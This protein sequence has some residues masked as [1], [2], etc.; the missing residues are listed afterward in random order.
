MQLHESFPVIGD[1]FRITYIENKGIA[2]SM[3]SESQN[4]FILIAMPIVIVV[5]LFI[6]YLKEK[7]KY[8]RLFSISIFM[9]IAGGISNLIDR[10]FYKSVTDFFDLKGFAI[11]NVADIFAVAGCIFLVISI[12]LVEKNRIP[13]KE[14][15]IDG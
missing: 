9:I 15:K 11:F 7:E 13:E 3:F 12:F 4:W 10:I 5:G 2:F 1:V 8:D 6:Y 14:N